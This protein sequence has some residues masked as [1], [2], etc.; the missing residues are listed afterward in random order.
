VA[1]ERMLQ[2]VTVAKEMPQKR[3]P[4]LRRHDFHE[5]Y[6]D[7]ADRKA[8]EQAGRCSQCPTARRIARSTTTSPTGCG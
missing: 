8:A 7:Y 2:F 1:K 3:P 6:A 5:I 4:D